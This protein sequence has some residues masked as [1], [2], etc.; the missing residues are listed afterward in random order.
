M[1]FWYNLIGVFNHTY[2]S[3]NS[4]KKNEAKVSWEKKTTAEKKK[5][6]KSSH[7]IMKSHNHCLNYILCHFATFAILSILRSNPIIVCNAKICNIYMMNK[8]QTVHIQISWVF[9]DSYFMCDNFVWIFMFEWTIAALGNHI[10]EVFRRCLF[11]S[12][13]YASECQVL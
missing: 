12:L 13:I 4:Q 5:L 2:S 1:M 7:I 9:A 8:C 11:S 6:E 3:G 10:L